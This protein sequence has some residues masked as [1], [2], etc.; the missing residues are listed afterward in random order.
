MPIPYVKGLSERLT[1][2]FKKHGVQ[3]YHKPFNTLRAQLVHPKDPTPAE[4]KSGV[5]YK[6]NCNE[7]DGDYIGETARNLGA[8]V[9]EHMSTKRA[10]L[11]SACSV[12]LSMV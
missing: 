7:C 5:I 4:K 10:R 3:T 2:V 6:I 12:N 8:R 1:K 11:T 9:K